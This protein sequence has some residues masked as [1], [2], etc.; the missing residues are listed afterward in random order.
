[1]RLFTTP[2]PSSNYKPSDLHPVESPL[3]CGSQRVLVYNT[4]PI[5]SNTCS[6]SF[7]YPQGSSKREGGHKSL[8][9]GPSFRNSVLLDIVFLFSV[10]LFQSVACVAPQKHSISSLSPLRDRRI[11]VEGTTIL[12]PAENLAHTQSRLKLES[13]SSKLSSLLPLKYSAVRW[14]CR[15]RNQTQTEER[16]ILNPLRVVKVTLRNVRVRLTNLRSLVSS[17]NPNK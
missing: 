3:I 2:K 16:L 5:S 17:S 8:L 9:V 15:P 1:M 10:L 4:L 11:R 14:S 12:V 6:L 13:L 7:K